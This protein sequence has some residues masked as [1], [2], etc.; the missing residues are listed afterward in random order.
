MPAHLRINKKKLLNCK[1]SSHFIFE[2]DCVHIY[3]S[4]VQAFRGC[5]LSHLI[6]CDIM[7]SN[8]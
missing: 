1:F 8:T 6:K 3:I 2:I 5:V 4:F 7:S